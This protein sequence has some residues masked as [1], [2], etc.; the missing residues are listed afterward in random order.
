MAYINI[1][2]PVWMDA[3]IPDKAKILYG[4]IVRYSQIGECFVQNK[5]FSKKLNCSTRT[6][7]RLIEILISKGLIQSELE[8][9]GKEVKRRTLNPVFYSIHVKN[10]GGDKN[11]RG[12]MSKM[13]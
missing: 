3:E 2:D 11:V 10:E 8:Y 12:V 9:S 13:S 6:V 7:A 1:P 5:H 4:L